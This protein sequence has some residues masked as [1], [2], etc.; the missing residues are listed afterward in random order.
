MLH[1]ANKT[2]LAAGA[3]P[4]KVVLCFRFLRSTNESLVSLDGL[5][6]LVIGL[7]LAREGLGGTSSS[8]RGGASPSLLWLALYLSAP[9]DKNLPEK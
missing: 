3:P 7:S 2:C 9:D 4:W 6:G 5:I 1:L 8:V